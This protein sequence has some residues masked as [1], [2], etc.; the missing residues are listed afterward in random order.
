MHLLVT[1]SDVV[2][3]VQHNEAHGLMPVEVSG[4]NYY[5]LTDVARD[6]GVSRQTLWRW[7]QDGKVPA[8]RKYRGR[9]I[10]FTA[11][12]LDSVREYANRLEPASPASAN[13]LKLFNGK[14]NGQ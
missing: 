11:S 10:L 14:G 7:R 4:V 3:T 2:D 6:V 1:E 5:L 9:Q 13:Q 12:E 8:G